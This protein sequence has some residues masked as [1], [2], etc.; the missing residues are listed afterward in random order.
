[1]ENAR[2]IEGVRAVSGETYPDPTR[3]VSIG[4]P[5]HTLVDNVSSKDWWYYSIESCGGTH[6]DITGEIK[7]MV[8]LEESGIAKGVRRIVVVTGQG[9]QEARQNAVRLEE[10]LVSL[11]Q[12]TTISPEKKT[13]VKQAQTELATS[14]ISILDKKVLARPLEGITKE[15]LKEQ[16][17]SLKVQVNA[18]I[19]L[20][21]TA[22]EQDTASTSFV[23]QL[24]GADCC[25]KVILEAI[26]QVSPRHDDKS[27]YFIGLDGDAGR[28]AH[29]CFVSQGHTSN[30]LVANEWAVQV[31]KAVGGKPGGKGAT[32]MGSG[33]ET[34]KVEDG[35]VA[36]RSYLRS[37]KI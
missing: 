22:I 27:T 29:G 34:T 18:A 24:P 20:V 14:S 8:M 30:G 11:E 9:A 1:M 21:E 31:A 6:V 25:A 23:V 3:V 37:L 15:M 26:K 16:K 7:D 35:I 2:Q 10:R 36:A 4:V 17:E 33:T 32:S 5:V 28:V 13:L 19:T 12:M